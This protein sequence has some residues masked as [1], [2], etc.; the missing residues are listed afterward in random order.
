[1]KIENGIILSSLSTLSSPEVS[2]LKNSKIA[3]VPEDC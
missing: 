2:F 3:P 1:M